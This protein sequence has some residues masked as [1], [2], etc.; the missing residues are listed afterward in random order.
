MNKISVPM[1]QWY[2]THTC[3]LSCDHCLSFNNFRVSGNY[4]WVDSAASAA[5]WSQLIDIDDLTI[6]GGEPLLHPEID[7]WVQ[8]IR[9][10]FPLVE[11]F[12]VCTNGTRLE[13]M[14]PQV[15][16]GW[17]DR[18]V[19]LELHCHSPQHWNRVWTVLRGIFPGLETETFVDRPALHA[20]ETRLYRG[21][22]LFATVR[23]SW[24]FLPGAVRSTS[25]GLLEFYHTDPVQSHRSCEI[26]QCHYIVDG[27]MYKC[28]T[29]AA[30]ATVKNLQ[31]ESRAVELYSVYH[32]VDH[33]DPNL[34]V[35]LAQLAEPTP[36]CALCPIFGSVDRPEDLFEL[37]L[38]GSKPRLGL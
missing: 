27:R 2:I 35:R 19:I 31:M 9:D 14:D 34:A 5:G 7:S 28:G 11:D 37:D 10:C 8:G 23:K 30:G 16:F 6:I 29:I 4:S 25:G 38:K 18:G 17:E 3:N 15:L 12:K 21:G 24:N 13:H 32:P 1:V 20:E 26:R 36:Q 33:H 22:K